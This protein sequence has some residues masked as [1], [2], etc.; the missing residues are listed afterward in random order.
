MERHKSSEES[1]TLSSYRLSL[2]DVSRLTIDK[3]GSIRRGN[4][5]LSNPRNNPKTLCS[6]VMF[7][8]I[9]EHPLEVTRCTSP[10]GCLIQDIRHC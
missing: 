4:M 1:E 5:R 7:I 2:I 10:L 6:N 9:E 8:T 3:R